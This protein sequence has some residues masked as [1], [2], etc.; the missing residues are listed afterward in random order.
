M[1]IGVYSLDKVLYQGEAREVNCR[2]KIGEITILQNHEPIIS[3]L[4]RGTM[5]IVDNEAK[6]HYIPVS[7]GFLEFKQNEGRF[8]VEEERA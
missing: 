8:L 6:E 2:T 1:K 4:D 5:K 3:I 7:S